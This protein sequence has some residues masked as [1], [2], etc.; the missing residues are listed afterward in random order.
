MKKFILLL[1]STYMLFANPC[2]KKLFSLSTEG[3]NSI[4]LQQIITDLSDTCHLNIIITDNMAK[5]KLNENIKYIKLKNLTLNEFLNFLL[6]KNGFFYSLEDNLLTISYIKTQHFKIDYINSIITGNS[7]F[8]ASTDSTDGSNT[9]KSEF[10]FDFWKHFAQNIKNILN[11]SKEYGFKNPDPI[12]D[13]TSGLVTI[14]GTKHQLEDIKKYI[15]EVNKRLHKEVLINVKIY[16]VLLSNSNQTGINWSNLN[17]SLG[18][19][20]SPA[21]SSLT[22]NNILGSSSIF[23]NA[24]FNASG[25]LNFLATQGNVNSISNPKIVTL[26]NQKAI[27][28]VG[29]TINYREMT[30]SS[31]VDNNG[32]VVPPSYKNSSKFVGILL[33]ITPEISE[34][35][36]IILRINPT[37]SV[38]RNESQL[39]DPN[40]LLP[41]DTTDNKLSTIVRM[42][43]G[44]T[45]V[46][47]GLITHKNSFVENG[48]PV[49]KEIPVLKY[50]FSSK[51]KISNKK[52]LVFVITP[53]IINL[54]KLRDI[55]DLDYAKPEKKLPKL[56]DL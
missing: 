30:Q 49:L 45:L 52:E 41:P 23:S 12:I 10:S 5:R 7:N 47:G 39:T 53:H 33:D 25:L 8:S 18:S 13:E 21:S 34:D 31:Y 36:A 43:D 44:Q 37:I 3:E 26:N 4:N 55:T 1:I 15:D 32:N 40:R 6:N 51:S 28:S 54:K 24:L 48:V 17:L 50:L 9:L 19:K 42:K 56:G 16:S 46:L 2:D 14:V 22:T 35:G 38:F 11:S 20:D 27:I 29:D